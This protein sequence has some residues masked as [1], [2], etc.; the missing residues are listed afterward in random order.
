MLERITAALLGLIV[1]WAGGC[2]EGGLT[3]RLDLPEEPSL[4]PISGQAVTEVALVV[5]G[6]DGRSQRLS[7]TGDS[8]D[9][10]SLGRLAEGEVSLS[11]ELLGS[12]GRLLGYGRAPEPVAVRSGADVEVAINVRR[13]LVYLSGHPDELAIFDASEDARGAITGGVSLGQVAAATAT[14]ADGAEIFVATEGASGAAITTLSTSTHQLSEP[15]ASIA[16]RVGDLAISSAGFAAIAHRSDVAGAGGGVTLVD[17]ARPE[18]P[19]HLELGDTRRVIVDDQRGAIY[20]LV[21]PT[22]ICVPAEPV[23][24]EIVALAIS[25]DNE[26][27]APLSWTGSAADIALDPA[28]GLLYVADPCAGTI[29]SLDPQ[30]SAAPVP[31]L[32]LPAASAVAIHEGMLIAAGNTQS[33]GG[34]A[35]ALVSLDL[36]T[37]GAEPVITEL[38]ALKERAVSGE[39]DE[40]GQS[41]EVVAGAD[42]AAVVDMAAVP[43]TDR[44]ALVS[45]AAF[46]IAASVDSGFEVTPDMLLT[47]WEYQVV[48]ATGALVQRVRTRCE[49]EVEIDANTIFTVWDCGQADNQSVPAVEFEPRTLN[50]LFGSR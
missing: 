6:A 16:G 29:S 31:V 20:A 36:G 3:I 50:V 5:R 1:P 32:D 37:P 35:L 22:V 46:A 21:R 8:R 2:G 49:L 9:G 25:L 10:L 33:T 47:A 14:S 45:L 34:V 38:P 11:V 13:P 15:L 44:I 12:T 24:A 23:E 43:G 40:G 30:G 41:V 39:L 19:T 18:T 17:L 48:D 42:A 26:T 7:R 27:P 28:T 4:S